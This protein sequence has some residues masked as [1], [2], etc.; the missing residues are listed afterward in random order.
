MS[1]VSS[2]WMKVN[3]SMDDGRLRDDNK[4]R[5]DEEM[6]RM[7]ELCAA[8]SCL[9]ASEL[10]RWQQKESNGQSI[11]GVLSGWNT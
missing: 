2:N 9:G 7:M 10:T 3:V 4:T 8:S 5:F 11:R 6:R 1:G